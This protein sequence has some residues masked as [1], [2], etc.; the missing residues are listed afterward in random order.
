V[1]TLKVTARQTE[2]L[3]RLIDLWRERQAPIHYTELAEAVGVNKYSAYDM[4]RVLESKG[5]AACDYVLAASHSG[6]GRSMVVFYPTEQ[7]RR[8]LGENGEP[9]DEDWPGTRERL[10]R[11]LRSV[12]DANLRETLS[13]WLSRLPDRR[14]PLDY[15]A[16]M[17]AA[18]LLNLRRLRDRP[19]NTFRGLWTSMRSDDPEQAEAA[20]ST[21][22]GMSLGASLSD[23]PE[24]GSADNGTSLMQRLLTAT[25]HYQQSLA[26]L[27]REGKAALI[28][29]LEEALEA[30]D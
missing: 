23:E 8:I 16:N 26:R 21:L 15:S 24:P 27:S 14:A 5:L 7:G 10:L 11:R 17:A 9:L 30:L 6:P 13:D 20:L 22:A 19:L 29:F 4:L 2:F 3:Q 1:A 18:L 25:G 12:R 28:E